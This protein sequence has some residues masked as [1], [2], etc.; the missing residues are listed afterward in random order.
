[1][2]EDEIRKMVVEYG[3][4]G[5]TAD[6]AFRLAMDVERETRHNYFRLIQNA[7][8]AASSKEITARDIDKLVWDKSLERVSKK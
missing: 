4:N 6:V 2:T 7:N 5:A 8:N 3:F 1:M